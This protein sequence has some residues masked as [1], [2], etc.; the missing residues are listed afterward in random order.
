MIGFRSTAKSPLLWAVMLV[1]GAKTMAGRSPYALENIGNGLV[2]GFGAL[3]GQQKRLDTRAE[4]QATIDEEADRLSELTDFHRNDIDVR[5]RQTARQAEADQNKLTV[6]KGRNAILQQQA[7]TAARK[8]DQDR[9]SN[10]FG[11]GPDPDDPSK[12]LPGIWTMS[13][14]QGEKPSFTPGASTVTMQKINQGIDK[15]GATVRQWD[16]TLSN[17]RGGWQD[18]GV[19]TTAQERADAAKQNADTRAARV[20]SGTGAPTVAQQRINTSIDQAREQ[21]GKLG[22]PYEELVRRSQVQINGRPN[23]NFDP[24]LMSTYRRAVQPKYGQDAGY[25]DFMKQIHGGSVSASPTPGTLTQGTSTSAPSSAS[26][27]S[28]GE[29]PR[30]VAPPAL[31]KRIG[32]DVIEGGRAA[33]IY[34][35]PDGSFYAVPK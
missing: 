26:S 27:P 29:A 21:I 23:P 25:A 19:P 34:Q 11:Y 6:D 18:T 7:D 16:P 4:K 20:T 10:Q 30:S 1:A 13:T 31:D 28:P 3:E 24:N 32:E 9:F 22:L 12:Q 5:N 14:R 8:A 33:V 15:A 35:R 17:G 2:A